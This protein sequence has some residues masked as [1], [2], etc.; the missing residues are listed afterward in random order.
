MR[1]FLT[2]KQ[3]REITTLSFAEMARREEKGTFPR[4]ERLSADPRGRVG[5]PED[6]IEKWCDSPAGYR[7]ESHTD[8]DAP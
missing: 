3:V 4:R 2:K 5:Y 7:A 8:R 6:E 1:R